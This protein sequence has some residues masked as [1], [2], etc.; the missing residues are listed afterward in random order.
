[1]L[2]LLK[3]VARATVR[4]PNPKQSNKPASLTPV[5][6]DAVKLSTRRLM[7]GSTD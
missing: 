3:T 7:R 4:N 6:C 1:M 2:M 5:N